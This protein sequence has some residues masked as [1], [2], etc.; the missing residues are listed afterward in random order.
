MHCKLFIYSLNFLIL[1]FFP[2]FYC[3]ITS[4]LPL[5]YALQDESGT[6]YIFILHY[7]LLKS[8]VGDC[9][10]MTRIKKRLSDF[11][12]C[13]TKTSHTFLLNYWNVAVAETQFFKNY[14]FPL[15][16]A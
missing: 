1:K 6:V 7:I 10:K 12:Q 8:N 16:T 14:S 15:F 2:T 13:I 3:F 5:G 4:H 11:L 9:E